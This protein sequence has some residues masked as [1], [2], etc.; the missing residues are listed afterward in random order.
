[1]QADNSQQSQ[2]LLVQLF[3]ERI[4]DAKRDYD[5]V[6]QKLADFSSKH[7][8]YSLDGQ[9]QQGISKYP[10][11]ETA[12]YLQL[13]SEAKAK[14][15][16]YTNL[17]QQREED[18]IQEAME[19]RDIQLIDEANLPKAPSAP[20]KKLIAAIGLALGCVIASGYSLV[21][22]KHEA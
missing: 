2:N 18:K 11:D 14:K 19:S 10:P 8:L 9:L 15:N 20:R 5:D 16:I 21:M 1:M 13:K 7:G 6:A 12:T 3:D 4:E 17:V 22:Y